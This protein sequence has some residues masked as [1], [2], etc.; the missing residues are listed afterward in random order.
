MAKRSRRRAATPTTLD[1]SRDPLA[2][3]GRGVLVLKIV[4]LI[5]VFDPAASDAFSLPKVVAS[6][7]TTYLLAAIVLGLV[8]RYRARLFR[9]SALYV[10]AGAYLASNA[11]AAAFAL[12]PTLALYGAPIRLLG[13]TTLFDLGFTMF[14]TATLIRSAQDLRLVLVALLAASIPV[15]V[16]TAVEVAGRDPI[17]WA[18]PRITST[19]GNPAHL[20]AYLAIVASV[21][22]AVL[23]VS[24]RTLG[25]TQRAALG[26]LAFACALTL[27]PV[28]SRAPVLALGVGIAAALALTAVRQR[29]IAPPVLVAGVAL[30]AV[31]LFAVLLSPIADRF[32]TLLSGGDPSREILWSAALQMFTAHPIVGIGPDNFAAA[33]P[34]LRTLRSVQLVGVTFLESSP[35]SWILQAAVSAGT[36]GAVTLVVAT[37]YVCYRALR[38]V[39]VS[40]YA[41]P[42]LAG[43]A[44]FL[45]QA[46]FAPNEI[47]LDAL[48]W[49]SLGLI[50]PIERL[51]APS[52]TPPQ[53]AGTHGRTAGAWRDLDA[54]DAVAGVA[55]VA[56]LALSYA[57]AWAPLRASEAHVAALAS[58]SSNDVQQALR[59]ARLSVDLDGSRAQY[60]A[61]LGQAQLAAGQPQSALASFE[62][63]AAIAP[64]LSGHWRN[65]A[66]TKLQLAASDR[67]QVDAAR[68][69]AERA[70]A[71]QP[72][73]PL[74][75]DVLARVMLE[76]GDRDGA[77]REGLRALALWEDDR[78]ARQVVG[79]AY[80]QLG[81]YP[82]AEAVVGP[83][84]ETDSGF[85]LRLLLAQVLAAE[86]RRDEARMHIN[87]VLDRDP[88]NAEAR[89]LIATL[90]T[91]P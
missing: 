84:I 2:A 23:A 58:V 45:A 19:L 3:V 91:A 65:V 1:L 56:V 35:H 90:G 78:V 31:A 69:A 82:E 26:G 61:G 36:V 38:L 57:V 66:N 14:A 59:L 67:S 6:R 75:H 5:V 81:R 72:V 64:Y 17:A 53:R 55:L 68:K 39:P 28:G 47:A 73:D 80:A 8:L 43:I 60:W 49:I 51:A 89:R 83:G 52:S 86:G 77:I 50:I 46:L 79:V 20:G 30:V 34:S 33:Y 29:R 4:L 7:V 25:P 54:L 37:A 27:G 88:S 70:V 32:R 48:F 42:L 44:A 87:Y 63:A 13:L 22:I 74:A 71:A 62:R 15:L 85:E 41:V 24:W 9:W 16:Y 18:D 21:S 10:L 12:D 76:Q 40:P 11:L